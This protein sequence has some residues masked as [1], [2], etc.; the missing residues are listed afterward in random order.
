MNACSP[1]QPEHEG[2]KSALNEGAFLRQHARDQ[3]HNLTIEALR[4][5]DSER[6]AG[7]VSRLGRRPSLVQQLCRLPNRPEWKF[8]Q[9]HILHPT[10]SHPQIPAHGKPKIRLSGC[11]CVLQVEIGLNFFVGFWNED[12]QYVDSPSA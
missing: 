11:A 6:A 10:Q 8:T 9:P 3:K 5:T 1:R 12:G 7:P 4:T 2:I